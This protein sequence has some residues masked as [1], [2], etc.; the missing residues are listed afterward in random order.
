MDND[1]TLTVLT[2]LR[3]RVDQLLELYGSNSDLRDVLAGISDELAEPI[4]AAEKA[5]DQAEADAEH[6]EWLRLS[7]NGKY[8]VSSRWAE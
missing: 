5:I 8:S 7:H 2:Q 6:M 1:E 3:S 4:A